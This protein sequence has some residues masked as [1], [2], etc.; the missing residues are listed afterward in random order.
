M[1]IFGTRGTAKFLAAL[2]T[3]CGFCRA[4]AAQRLYRRR[5][6]F[7]LFFIPI[8][9][10]GHGKYV[11]QCANCGE[12]SE[13]PREVADRFQVDAA[14]QQAARQAAEATTTP[15]PYSPDAP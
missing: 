15:A 12:Q 11:M 8:F 7:T 4:T 14:Q 13:L 1:I 10:F 5:T 2:F 6:W 9:P 3:V